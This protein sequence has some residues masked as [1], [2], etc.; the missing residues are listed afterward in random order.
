M[1]ANI[2]GN[3]ALVPS[4]SDKNH[5]D[6][7]GAQRDPNKTSNGGGG[8]PF[9]P[10][11]L[12][13]SQDFA[14]S[15]GVKKT[16]RTVPARKPNRHDWVRVHPTW[17]ISPVAMLEMKD[18]GTTSQMYLIAPSIVPELP[19]GEAKPMA[20]F[21][22]ITRQGTF[23]VWPVRVAGADGRNDAWSQSAMEA[24]LAAQKRWV[25]VVSNTQ[26]GAYEVYESD[27][28]AE[29]EWPADI[30]NFERA[31]E[32]AFRDKFIT[33]LDHPVLRRLRGEV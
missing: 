22:A 32:L 25:R 18:E 4:S 20:L 19:P 15:I 28:T 8:S 2:N 13:M 27:S 14:A 33:T 17:S 16:T 29:P 23:F 9:D 26:L 6:E 21:G 30:T 1:S 10:K 7:T 24:A 11:Q 31:I 5:A 12:V 3:G